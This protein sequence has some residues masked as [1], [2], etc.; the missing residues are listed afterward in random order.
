MEMQETLKKAEAERDSFHDEMVS[1]RKEIAQKTT[2]SEREARK[3]DRLEKEMKDVKQTLETRQFEIKQ[4]Q[5]QVTFTRL[6]I[7]DRWRD[8]ADRPV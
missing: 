4:K 1:L 7:L 5:A 2:E 6:S 8:D 3:K